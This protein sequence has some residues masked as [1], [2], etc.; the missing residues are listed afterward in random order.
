MHDLSDVDDYFQFVRTKS[1]QL[2]VGIL[3]FKI[4]F[5]KKFGYH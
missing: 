3:L 2:E 5:E 1:I 4:F